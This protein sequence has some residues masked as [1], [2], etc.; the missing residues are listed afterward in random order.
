MR[1]LFVISLLHFYSCTN[2]GS[3]PDGVDFVVID[4]S[5]TL[6]HFYYPY[7]QNFRFENRNNLDSVI[8]NRESQKRVFGTYLFGLI[9]RGKQQPLNR[10]IT[11]RGDSGSSF[12]D[13]SDPTKLF[14]HE[15]YKLRDYE[16]TLINEYIDSTTVPV[17]KHQM[18]A[19]VSSLTRDTLVF[20]E[21]GITQT[22][23]H[24]VYSLITYKNWGVRDEMHELITDAIQKIKT[25]TED[26]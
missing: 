7:Y 8:F 20:Q 6:S 15:E 26:Q 5:D 23:A 4:E 12:S 17:S 2:K 25:S 18:L 24:V 3:E 19:A 13:F 10:Y 9:E 1:Y 16:L 14:L 11:F 21:L 22:P